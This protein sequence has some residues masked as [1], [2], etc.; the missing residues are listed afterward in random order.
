MQ[1]QTTVTLGDGDNFAITADDA[2]QRVLVALGGD[3]GKDFSTALV[4]LQATGSH[5]EPLPPPDN[6][7]PPLIGEVA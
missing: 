5:G 4:Q 7:T 2:A 6:P 3:P 1:I